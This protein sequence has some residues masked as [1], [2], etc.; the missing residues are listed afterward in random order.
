MVRPAG[1]SRG[2]G[3]AEAAKLF[4]DCEKSGSQTRTNLK[5]H[6]KDVKAELV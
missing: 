4:S 1:F 6:T 3:S 2:H 5:K